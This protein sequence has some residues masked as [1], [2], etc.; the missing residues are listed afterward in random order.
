MLRQCV[1]AF[2][3]VFVQKRTFHGPTGLST[4]AQLLCRSGSSC[5]VEHML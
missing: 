1:A 4:R 2:F 3:E 5:Q